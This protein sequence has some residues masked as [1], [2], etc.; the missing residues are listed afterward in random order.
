[1]TGHRSHEHYEALLMKAVDG[2]LSADERGELEDHLTSCEACAAEL[3]DFQDIKRTTDAMTERILC[4]AQIEPPRPAAPAVALLKLSFTLLLAGLLILMGFAVYTMAIDSQVPLLIKV[5]MA[6]VG[7]G[8]LGLLGYALRIR[9]RAVGRD[10][11]E[12]IDR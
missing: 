12:E 9:A 4:D 1:M 11:Y 10:P 2:L 6:L 7:A 5:A 3:S 8:L